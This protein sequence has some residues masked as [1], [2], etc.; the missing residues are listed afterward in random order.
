MAWL[1]FLYSLQFGMM[2]ETVQ[3]VE[4]DEK[5]YNTYDGYYIELSP[6]II[7]FDIFYVEGTYENRFKPY[8]GEQFRPIQDTFTVDLSAVIE[9][10]KAKVTAGYRHHCIHPVE[11][12]GASSGNIYGGGNRFYIEVSNG[13][14]NN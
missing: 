11:T 3:I 7:L 1:V 13:N 8:D 12:L 9:F 10:D 5:A 14:T 4:E 6:T 2:D